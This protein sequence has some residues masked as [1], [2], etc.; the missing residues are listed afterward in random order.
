MPPPVLRKSRR[1][2][3]PRLPNHSREQAALQIATSRACSPLIFAYRAALCS[4]TVFFALS[5]GSIRQ[6][7][8]LYGVRSTRPAV[9][10]GKE[11]RALGSQ[12]LVRVAWAALQTS[13]SRLA[14]WNLMHSRTGE[15]IC[16]NRSRRAGRLIKN[17]AA[18]DSAVYAQRGTGKHNIDKPRCAP[19]QACANGRRLRSVLR[20][21]YA[22]VQPRHSC[23]AFVYWC[24]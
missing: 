13:V 1:G 11:K 16:K 2:C 9:K 8:Y 24:D 3:S 7:L 18:Q 6:P 14:A 21:A 19:P 22:C 12:G 15:D 10:P 5:Q 4:V 20:A 23:R 17:A